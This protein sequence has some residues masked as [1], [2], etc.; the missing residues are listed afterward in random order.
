MRNLYPQIDQAYPNQRKRTSE[1]GYEGDDVLPSR[2]TPEVELIARS[3]Y[4]L[5]AAEMQTIMVTRVAEE[6]ERKS[7]DLKEK[8]EKTAS[9]KNIYEERSNR[10]H[11]EGRQLES[12]LIEKD[13]EIAKLKEKLKPKKAPVKKKPTK[14]ETK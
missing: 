5:G 3:S 2:L 9:D 6:A 10:Y 4:R 14:S 11:T 1:P 7:Y 12:K 13:T 8:L